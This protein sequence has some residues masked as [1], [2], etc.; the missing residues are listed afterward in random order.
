MKATSLVA[1]ASLGFACCAGDCTPRQD[2]HAPQVRNDEWH[3]QST[4][5]ELD[6]L[7][8]S[9]VAG[10]V[11]VPDEAI[12]RAQA[13][14]WDRLRIV[15]EPGGAAALAALVSGAYVPAKDERVCVL[16]CG[17]NTTAVDFSR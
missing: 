1:L 12:R 2:I 6:A 3:D 14:L 13:L 7:A 4:T 16:V 5:V 9:L 17:G 10:S 8:P 15:T 11:L